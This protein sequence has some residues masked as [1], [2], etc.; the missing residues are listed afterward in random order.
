MTRRFSR[1]LELR[2]LRQRL[3]R[4]GWPRV[5][6]TTLV[7]ATAL[8]GFFFS[9]VLLKLGWLTLWSR[10]LLALAG[11][12]ALFLGLLGAWLHW[13]RDLDL[14]HVDVPDFSTGSDHH[15]A[16][17]GGMGGHGGSSAGGGASARFDDAAS[18]DVA[19]ADHGGALDALG[20]GVGNVV[21]SVFEAEEAA[22]PLLLLLIVLAVAGSVLFAS[23]W[24]VVSA[25]ALFA[26][27]LLDV[28]LAAGLYRRLR[29]KADGHWLETA[30]RRTWAPFLV[31][32]VVLVAA[33]FAIQH[34][35][36]QAHT[37]GEALAFWH[38]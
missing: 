9:A 6:M 21:G 15:H 7:T 2:R 24:L 17:G 3:E 25:P 4:F 31:A 13:R 30:L 33:G 16:P 22:I 14:D 10:W 27:L 26:E 37:L 12:Y 35:A 36:P 8:G 28:L 19:A 23:A 11:A 18:M 5:E 32:A 1:D 38:A 29:A 20:D 34:F